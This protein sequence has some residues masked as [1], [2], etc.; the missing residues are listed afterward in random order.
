LAWLLASAC[1]AAEAQAEPAAPPPAALRAAVGFDLNVLDREIAREMRDNP[2]LRGAWLFVESEMPGD[3]AVPGK[4]RFRRVLD[5]RRAAA[6]RQELSRLI[7]AWAPAGN[8]RVDAKLDR[9]YPFSDL[10]A[11]LRLA[12]ETEPRLGGCMISGGYYAADENEPGKLNLVLL[13]RIAKE[14]QDVEIEGLCGSLMRTDP[15]WVKPSAGDSAPASDRADFIPLA[16]SPTSAQLTVVEPSEANGRWFYA[17]GLN[18]FWR[19]E[20][21]QAAQSF[22]QAALESPRKLQYQYWWVL[23]DLALGDADLARRRMTAAVERFRDSNFDRQ[24]PEYLAVVR[25]LERVQGPLRRQLL[26]LE[27]EALVRDARVGND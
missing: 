18:H 20:Y 14:G 12:V 15:A 9:E 17:A 5:R 11:D 7:A 19:D 23:S 22:R 4:L 1:I 26:K 6:Q 2:K 24:S 25:S 13:G 16:I 3:A 10:M 21:A 8:Y 27:T